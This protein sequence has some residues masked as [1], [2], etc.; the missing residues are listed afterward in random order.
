MGQ[1]AVGKA[2]DE[3]AGAA[4]LH[5][6]RDLVAH[7]PR[8]AGDDPRG[9][10]AHDI[11]FRRRRP[12]VVLLPKQTEFLVPGPIAISA[13]R[14]SDLVGV[15]DVNVTGDADFRRQ[16]SGGAFG[17][18][19]TTFVSIDQDPSAACRREECDI[20]A[21]TASPCSAFG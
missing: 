13:F 1:I 4:F 16:P 11:V 8:R 9:V 3:I 15:G 18:G 17:G 12:R 5:L 6:S 2:R 19:T 14:V 21:L 20:V 7:G 10:A